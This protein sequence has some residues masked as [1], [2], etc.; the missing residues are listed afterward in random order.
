MREEMTPLMKALAKG[1]RMFGPTFFVE[2]HIGYK[3]VGMTQNGEVIS[4]I[5]STW[6]EA[7]KKL[8]EKVQ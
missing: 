6:A 1:K 5:G 4:A 2:E 7:I 3:R 8:K